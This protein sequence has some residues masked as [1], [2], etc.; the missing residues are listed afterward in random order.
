MSQEK[1]STDAQIRVRISHAHT[2]KDG[3]RCDSTTVE[4]IGAE[5][6][7]WPLIEAQ[8]S[9]AYDVARTETRQ[10]NAHEAAA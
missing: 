1:K 7:D 4:W 3:W 2:L 8:M 10:R 9:T 6:V 5:P